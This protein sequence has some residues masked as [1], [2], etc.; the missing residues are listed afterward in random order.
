[1]ANFKEQRDLLRAIN[2]E[3]GKKANLVRNA[4]KEVSKLESI[5]QKLQNV[6]SGIIT[7]TDRQALKEKERAEAALNALKD[8]AD[9]LQKLVDTRQKSY[10]S[11]TDQEKAL[12]A[13]RKEG[14][15]VEKE[16]L[17]LASKEVRI[18]EGI[19]KSMGITGALA[20]SLNKTLGIDLSS[21]LKDAEK[22]ARKVNEEFEE[23][24]G[25]V[26]A[27]AKR[28]KGNAKVFG[29][30]IKGIGGAA[31]KSIT[32]IQ[33]VLGLL[34]ASFLKFNKV[35]REARQLTGQTADNFTVM[36][37]SILNAAD[38]VKTITS[39]SSELGINVNAA[40]SAETIAAA[41]ELTQLLGISE[42]STA[43]LAQTAEAFG[44]DLAQAEKEAVKQVKALAKSGKG[45]LNFKQV[46]EESG[47]ASGRLQLTL[48][49]TPGAL[50][51]AAA[52][53]Q[54]LGLS[55][56]SVEKVADSLLNF[57]QSISSEL[58]AE[59]LTGKQI[60]LDK[61]RSLALNNDIA[62]LTKEIGNN[63]EILNA[64]ADGN[65]I[66]QNAIAQAMGLSVNEISEMIFKQ[67]IAEGLSTEQAA[68]AAN[69]NEE[70]AKRL[71]IQAQMQKS[72]EKMTMA[73]APLV[74]SFASLLGNAELMYGVIAALAAVKLG[75]LVSS[76]I[77]LATSLAAAGVGASATANAL[78]LG[79]ASVAI[80]GGI[81][82]VAAAVGRAKNKA[83]KEAEEIK[84]IK[85]GVI[86]AQGGLMVSGP[87]GSIS[88]D[89]EDT[90]I[91]NKN[92]VIAGTSLGGN[93]AANAEMLS[94]LDRLISATEK[95]SQITMDGNLVGKSI[96][97][98]TSALG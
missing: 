63:Q 47:N 38:Q 55:L 9:N 3:L 64:F 71:D 33:G 75:G 98:N 35:N 92:G 94:R 84:S 66:Q 91:A 77:G 25:G 4:T 15:T 52:E 44:Q 26:E 46:L 85:D 76:I 7:L 22:M 59:L 12:L 90:I 60:N 2:E 95:G 43:A 41:S 6:Q 36:N 1:V 51:E 57:E 67:K 5:T 74:E 42:K 20:K 11:L 29:E 82:L 83:K 62:G 24:D 97:N 93:G 23:S 21:A 18:R 88:L 73:A 16:T 17:K 31:L 45:A 30:Q 10:R 61:A 14:F 49:K 13:A 8:E 69:I 34:A 54:A 65:R 40:F 48:G 96:A 19:S 58:E 87:K 39:L 56:D 80:I 78:T 81:A 70:E 68:K 32:S 89:R 37:D 86:D 79:V 50:Q 27:Q 28:A 72:I 53:A